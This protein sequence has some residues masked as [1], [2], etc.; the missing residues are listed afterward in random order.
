MLVSLLSS[1]ISAVT[2]G[3]STQPTQQAMAISVPDQVR[4]CPAQQL[5]KVPPRFDA[6]ECKSMPLRNVNPQ[7]QHIWV[8][9]STQLSQ[10]AVNQT[11][12]LLVMAKASSEIF[13]NGL[14][15][16]SNGRPG[17]SANTEVPGQMD[18]VFRLK[19]GSLVA[20]ENHIALRMSSHR[21]WLPLDQPVHEVAMVPFLNIQDQI[22]RQYLP[23]L[24]PLGVFVLAGFYFLSITWRSE[25]K[26]RP[27]LLSLLSLLASLQLLLEV[28]RGVFAY[29][30]P[31]HDLRLIGILLSSILISVCLVITLSVQF[32]PRAAHWVLGTLMVVLVCSLIILVPGMD[33]KATTSLFA[34]STLGLLA[35]LWGWWQGKPQALAHVFA[36]AL[37]CVLNY[38]GGGIFLDLYLFYLIA[39]LLVFLVMQQA[40]N[41]AY[42]LHHERE[43]QARM[44]RLQAAT[45]P[46]T[47]VEDEDIVLMVSSAGKMQRVLAR[48]IA[49]VQGAGDYAEL[50]LIGG[51][52]FLH[53]SGLNELENELPNYF[54][55]AHRSHIVNTRYVER[56]HRSEGGTGFLLM[57][58]GKSVP[59][60]R[61]IMPNMRKALK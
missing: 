22:L 46:Q 60:S 13:L 44:D 33:A 39:F 30:Y 19:A 6:A 34:V 36:L 4:V 38:F 51:Q 41:Y 10:D 57:H 61:R 1:P 21:G 43:Q 37:F 12:G 27:G 7:H 48:D 23:A 54:L 31:L 49:H 53:T 17:A 15:V 26:L 3:A 14:H 59:V 25:D 8:G 5:D 9:W 18:V 24:L 11:V 58:N 20:G 52:H 55:R 29:A 42:E 47:V 2:P 50:H 28:S 45:V 16:G 56:L 35:A 40:I 32:L